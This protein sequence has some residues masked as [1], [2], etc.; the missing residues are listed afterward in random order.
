MRVLCE[1][2]HTTYDLPE[3][4]EGQIG[5]PYCE[6]VNVAPAPGGGCHP[7]NQ[8]SEKFDPM[9]TV[10]APGQ[11]DFGD[12]TTHARKV[13]SEKK[14]MLPAHQSLSFVIVDGNS[15]GK[16][17]PIHT[18]LISIGREKTDIVLDDSEVSRHHC[19]ILVFDD[20]IVVR[21]HGSTNGTM[22]R[23]SIVVASFIK[24]GDTLQVGLT[25]MK[26]EAQPK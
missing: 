13:V 18:A 23:G 4:K 21:D 16:K 8:P 14:P 11:A 12:E 7:N 24:P 2:C 10:I 20:I 3:G 6:H 22:V 26:L 15:I 17:F 1:G 25:V 9:R 19:N 5:C